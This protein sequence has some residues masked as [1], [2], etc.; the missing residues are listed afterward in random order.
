MYLISKLALRNLLRQK[1]RNIFLG[2]GI[3]F[4][5]MILVIANSFSNGMMDVLFNDIVTHVS[6]HIQINGYSGRYSAW[7]TMLRDKNR[8]MEAVKEV[9]PEEDIWYTEESVG[10]FGRGIGNGKADNVVIVGVEATDEFFYDFFTLIEGDFKDYT[11]KT[12][13]YP[14]IISPE[15]AKSL[16]V[17]LNDNIKVRL[18]NVKGQME[19]VSLTVIAIAKANNSFMNIVLFLEKDKAKKILGYEEWEAAA[20]L[21]NLKNPKK[22]AAKYADLLH[23]RLKPE[24]INIEGNIKGEKVNLVTYENDEN[25]KKIIFENIK[26]LSGD[27]TEYASKEGVLISKKIADNLKLKKGDK[28]NFEYEGKYKDK[29]IKDFTISAV[30]DSETELGEN[31]LLVNNEKGTEIYAKNI[32]KYNN[33][34]LIKENNKLYEY[35]GKEWKRF[36]RTKN[37]QKMVKKRKKYMSE[38]TKISKIDIVTMHEAAS[39]ILKLESALNLITIIGV[40]MLFFIILIGVINTLRMTVKERIKEIGTMRAIGM[41]KKDIKRL[42]VLETVYLTKISCIVGIISGLIVMKILGNIKMSL[43][44][45]LS[46]ILKN[47]YINFR[48]DIVNVLIIMLIIMLIAAVTSYFPSKKAAKM[49]ASNALRHYE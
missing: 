22:N 26:I 29:Y 36:E 42:F 32:P 47:G 33:T 25:S 21:V 13:E 11:S 34:E 45:A 39:E 14:V 9:I 5:M 16:N 4:G 15:K 48:F 6:G 37:Y 10:G 18:Q 35:L 24:I 30:Y 49:S 2:I 1:R 46:I 40:L 38:K 3:A 23:K 44:S 27:Y 20:I 8:V 28:I 19:S 17:K 31:I 41:Q 12:I 43:D 7:Y